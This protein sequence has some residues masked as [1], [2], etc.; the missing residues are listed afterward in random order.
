MNEVGGDN[1]VGGVFQDSFEIGFRGLLHGLANFLV[2]GVFGRANGEVHHA[3]RRGGNAEGHAGKFSL[4]FGAD[5]TDR[6]GGACCGGDDV[7]GGRAA[8]FPV[9]A[10][11]AVD[12]FLSG[13]VAVDGCHEALIHAKSLLEENV[14]EWGETVGGAGG[15]GDDVV[16]RVVVLGVVYPHDHGD[17][18][19]FGRSGDND[20]FTSCSDVALSFICF[21]KETGGLDDIIDSQILPREG[22]GAFLDG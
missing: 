20:F 21:G 1:F 5:E 7:N 9:F 2:R 11:R 4:N 19:A 6:F 22:R 18:L 14:D 3:D 13:G 17:I 8:T 15:V 16:L 10:G 12:R